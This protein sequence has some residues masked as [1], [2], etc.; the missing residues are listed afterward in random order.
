M[1]FLYAG[2]EPTDSRP[3]SLRQD[4]FSRAIGVRQLG[5]EADCTYVAGNELVFSSGDGKTRRYPLPSSSDRR[6]QAAVKIICGILSEKNYQYVYLSGFLIKSS[7]LKIAEFASARGF[8][9]HIIFE[10]THYPQEEAYREKLTAFRKENDKASRRSLRLEMLRQK[11]SLSR[12]MENIDTFVVFGVPVTEIFGI[13]AIT[14]DRGIFVNEIAPRTLLESEG[15]PIRLLGVVEDPEICGYE[16]ILT[17]LKAYRSNIHRDPIVFDIIGPESRVR[18]LRETAARLGVED[19][20][21]FLGEKSGA[22]K[23][24]VYKEHSVAVSC[25]GL[26]HSG[27]EYFSPRIAKEFCA[28]GL[29]FLY[30]YEDV[31][32]N[33]RMPF[34]LKLANLDAPISMELV[35]EFV[36]R[37]RLNP[38]LAREER[39]FA[40]ANY[41]WRVIMKKIIEFTATGR[42]DA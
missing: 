1:R 4:V 36:W 35:S 26:F 18:N 30:A 12:I 21:R 37:C 10:L 31:G 2:F 33:R 32:L 3:E 14:V 22:E 19:C 42:R 27:K 40:E 7:S 29:P 38:N 41:D 9:T 11:L 39:K 23:I 13:P 25:L 15:D 24:A 20:V 6:E 34:A 17:G 8:N 28:A 16:R 5:N